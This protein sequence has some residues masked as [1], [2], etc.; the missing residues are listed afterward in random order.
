MKIDNLKHTIKVAIL[1]GMVCFLFPFVL[2]R[3]DGEEELDMS[4]IEMMIKYSFDGDTDF[5]DE[6]PNY[7]LWIAFGLG[8]AGMVLA[9]RA[10]EENNHD[11]T[12]VGA[13]MAG[14]AAFLLFFRLS[15]MHFYAL[16]EYGDSISVEYK[17]GW[18]LALLAYIAASAMAFLSK[19]FAI[20][21]DSPIDD[22]HPTGD[23]DICPRCGKKLKPCARFCVYCRWEVGGPHPKPE[24]PQP[25]DEPRIKTAPHW[26]SGDSGKMHEMF[27]PPFPIGSFEDNSKSKL[28]TAPILQSETGINR[29]PEYKSVISSFKATPGTMEPERSSASEPAPLP[30]QPAEDLPQSA[31]V[32]A[33]ESTSAVDDLDS[34]VNEMAV[35]KPL[36]VCF[37]PEIKGEE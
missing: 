36:N 4:G 17:W 21:P 23:D 35:E 19:K 28:D 34:P 9:F 31:A 15:F 10:K 8:I 24:P 20:E 3:C 16:D 12:P 7:Y 32:P 27:K 26:N 11:L 13:T 5:E 1:I 6:A 14:G 18:V 2:V 30:T 29:E 22:P 37:E 25:D 33:T